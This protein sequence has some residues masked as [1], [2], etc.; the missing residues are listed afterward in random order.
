[1]AARFAYHFLGSHHIFVTRARDATKNTIV[2]TTRTT[3][4]TTTTTTTP[5]AT[6]TT[7]ITPPTPKKERT[8]LHVHIYKLIRT[9]MHIH[10]HSHSGDLV[11]NLSGT[12][13]EMAWFNRSLLYPCMADILPVSIA[14]NLHYTFPW[15]KDRPID[16]KPDQK[17]ETRSHKNK[18]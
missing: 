5:T 7:A 4:T 15:P 17:P 3:T 12:S 14:V 9:H 16:R 10:T 6:S 18:H 2:T 11:G 13:Y 1:M 8:R